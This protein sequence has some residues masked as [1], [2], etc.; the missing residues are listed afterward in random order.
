MMRFV[1]LPLLFLLIA[2]AAAAQSDPNPDAILLDATFV[3]C[4]DTTE[5]LLVMRDGRTVY[6]YGKRG[7]VIV[8]SDALL[9]D[10][11]RVVDSTRSGV[12]TEG[13]DSCNTL[14]IILEGPR[15]LL[16]NPRKPSPGARDLMNRVDRLRKY[17]QRRMDGTIDHFTERLEG[18][19]DT[20]MLTLPSVAPAD[21]RRKIRLSPVAR[22][23]RCSG[24]VVV[25]AM[26]TNQGKVRQAFVRDVRSRGKCSSILSTTALRAVLLTEFE[27][28]TS[29][30]GTPVLSWM[31]VE[32][33]F[34]RPK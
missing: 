17:A 12:G 10:L 25:A 18:E 31:E 9:N 16:I 21:I 29:R 30:K 7:A 32:V 3:E 22:E 24:T 13:L 14:G 1:S 15:Y 28:A 8:I 2:A 19:P 33:P 6:A 4:S 34:A 26:I 20:N 23:W 5:S 27:P 11:Q